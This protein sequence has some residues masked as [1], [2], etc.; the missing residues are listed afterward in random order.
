MPMDIRSAVYTYDV[1]ALPDDAREKLTRSDRVVITG[2]IGNDRQAEQAFLREPVTDQPRM[3]LAVRPL[4]RIRQPGRGS[5]DATVAFGCGL[6]GREARLIAV[7][8]TAA[9]LP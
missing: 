4:Y 9:P 1:S 6:L 3:L 2:A 7:D 5:M 8:T